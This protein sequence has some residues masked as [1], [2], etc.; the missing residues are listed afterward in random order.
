MENTTTTNISDINNTIEALDK[1]DPRTTWLS[2]H[3]RLIE[4]TRSGVATDKSIDNTPGKE[5]VDALRALCETY[6]NPCAIA[7]APYTSP[8][9][10]AAAGSTTPWAA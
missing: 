8:R 10:I 2:P 1:L 7:S 9:A 3:F 5:E 4:F 6:S